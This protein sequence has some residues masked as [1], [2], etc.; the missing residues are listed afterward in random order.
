MLSYRN[1]SIVVGILFILGTVTGVISAIIASP[2]LDAP[3]YLIQVSAKAG[4]IVIAAFIQ[5]IMAASCAGIGLALYPILRNFNEGLAIGS[6]GFRIIEATLQVIGAIF[7]IAILALSQEYIKGGV[8]SGVYQSIGT[9]IKAAS[10]WINSGA[11]LLTWCIGALMYYSIFYQYRL[12]P[13]WLSGWG[14]AGIVLTTISSTLV[15]LRIIPAFGIIQNTANFPIGIQEMVFAV[16]LI[17]KG[18]NPSVI[19]KKAKITQSK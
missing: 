6:T 15:M 18:L 1:N 16:W 10:E 19:V 13:R 5:F 7:M 4:P 12:V 17:V 3:D 14:L 11:M 9:M 2:I 8:D